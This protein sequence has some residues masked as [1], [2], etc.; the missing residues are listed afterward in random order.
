MSYAFIDMW[1]S[2][3]YVSQL[4]CPLSAAVRMNV[5]SDEVNLGLDTFESDYEVDPDSE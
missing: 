4:L 2:S 5:E 3:H 1:Y